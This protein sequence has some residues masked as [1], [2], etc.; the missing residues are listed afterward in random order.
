MSFTHLVPYA[1]LGMEAESLVRD[2]A[3]SNSSLGRA[4][5][6]AREVGVNVTGHPAPFPTGPPDPRPDP[7]PFAEVPYCRYP[8]QHACVDAGGN[9]LACP[10]AHGEPALGRISG[11]EPLAAAWLGPG[12]TCLRARILGS[13]PPA[14]CRRCSFL[15]G[16]HPHREELLA[17]REPSWG[18]AR[19]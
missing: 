15:A 1:G 6:R 3:L 13:D 12:F 17:V 4:L 9:V 18:G 11:D 16:R 14:M 10:F 8:F 19:P 2:R 7:D 5:A